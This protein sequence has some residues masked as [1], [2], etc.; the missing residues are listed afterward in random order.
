M[1]EIGYRTYSQLPESI[2]PLLRL[3]PL[4]NRQSVTLPKRI[5]EPR[6]NFQKEYVKAS[7]IRH[8]L[9]ELHHGQKIIHTGFAFTLAG[10][11]VSWESRKQRTAALSTAEAEYMALSEAA[12]KAIYL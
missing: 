8:R 5:V 2:Q 1:H 11:P 3:K 7:R 12:K 4:D 10:G 6:N 9:D